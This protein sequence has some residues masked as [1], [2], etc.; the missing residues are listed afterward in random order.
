MH[1]IEYVLVHTLRVKGA[2]SRT[3]CMCLYVMNE[4]ETFSHDDK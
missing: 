3:T 4:K 2:I 1:S